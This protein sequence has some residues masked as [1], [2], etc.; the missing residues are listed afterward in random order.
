MAKQSWYKVEKVEDSG[1]GYDRIFVNGR[2]VATV[3]NGFVKEG[4]EISIKRGRVYVAQ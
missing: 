3:D 4:D 1:N 2:M